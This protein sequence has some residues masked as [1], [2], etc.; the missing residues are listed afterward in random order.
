MGGRTSQAVRR[1]LPQSPRSDRSRYVWADNV[2][3]GFGAVANSRTLRR[4]LITR[5]GCQPE[6]EASLNAGAL[7]LAAPAPIKVYAS[8]GT[9]DPKCVQ[10]AEEVAT[11]PRTDDVEDPAV[12]RVSPF[13]DLHLRPP[14]LRPGHGSYPNS[15]SGVRHRSQPAS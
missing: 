10:R 3:F 6:V 12:A 9:A 14:G 11:V 13:H 7:S 15:C 5:R 8:T 1:V 4:R 2:R